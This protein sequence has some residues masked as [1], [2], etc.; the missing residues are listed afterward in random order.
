MQEYEKVLEQLIRMVQPEKLILYGT[1]RDV[2]TGTVKDI[3]VCLVAETP[4]KST[5]ERELYLS[6]DSDVSFDIIIYRPVEWET[7]IE[8][9]QSF[10]HRI[11]EKGT[12]VYERQA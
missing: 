7:L 11:L 9:H 5:L 10:A 2:A 3:D 8:D 4:D 12:V 6:I 1:K